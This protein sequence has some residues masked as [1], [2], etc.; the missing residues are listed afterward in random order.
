MLLIKEMLN[1]SSVN[2]QPLKNEKCVM[3]NQSFD[4][5]DIGDTSLC[6]RIR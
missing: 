1:Y 5:L 3:Q 4:A 6:H 2:F